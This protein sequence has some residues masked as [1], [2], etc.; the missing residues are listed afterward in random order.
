MPVAGPGL[1]GGVSSPQDGRSGVEPVLRM[2]EH[3]TL[4]SAAWT[5]THPRK[6]EW[7]FNN[8]SSYTQTIFFFFTALFIYLF[9]FLPNYEQNAIGG[10]NINVLLLK[11]PVG[12]PSEWEENQSNIKAIKNKCQLISSLFTFF[13]VSGGAHSPRFRRK[14]NSSSEN[15]LGGEHVCL[16]MG[17]GTQRAASLELTR[18][19]TG[20]ELKKDLS[21]SKI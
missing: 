6:E 5:E 11:L 1:S 9:I 21:G 15:A 8:S 2:S 7:V 18:I 20:H 14:T 16:C 13:T 4:C 12:S 19:I 10:K 17:N 3:T